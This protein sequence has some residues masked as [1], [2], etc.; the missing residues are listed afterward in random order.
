MNVNETMRFGIFKNNPMLVLFLGLT[1][2]LAVTG[3]LSHALGT[4]VVLLVLL[5]VSGLVFGAVKPMLTKEFQLPFVLVLLALL[6]KLSELLVL[7]YFPALGAGIGLY[8]PLLLVNSVLVF[9]IG[10][11]EEEAKISGILGNAVKAGLGYLLAL[12]LVALLREVV[13]SG[14]LLLT[15]PVSG[16]TLAAIPI[17]PTKYALTILRE[18]GGAFLSVALVAAVFQALGAREDRVETVEGGK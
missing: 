7:A 15:S 18:P 2:G 1:T 8:L 13:M 17:F 14:G 9:A 4:G 10:T 5:V 11:F 16:E 12:A 6:V 3:S